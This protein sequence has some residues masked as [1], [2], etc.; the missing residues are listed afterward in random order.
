VLEEVLSSYT[1]RWPFFMGAALILIVLY[2]PAGI[3][4]LRLRRRTR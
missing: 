1:Q 3:A 4:G 2:A